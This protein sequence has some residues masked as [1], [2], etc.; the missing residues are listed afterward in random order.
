MQDVDRLIRTRIAVTD[1]DKVTLYILRMIRNNKAG[2][3][4]I[5]YKKSWYE[6]K[7]NFDWKAQKKLSPYYIQIENPIEL[8]QEVKKK[9]GYVKIPDIGTDARRKRIRIRYGGNN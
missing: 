8:K 7:Y 9:A 4:V 5:K 1:G 6:V 3:G 2:S